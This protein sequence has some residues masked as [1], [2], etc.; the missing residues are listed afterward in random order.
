MD[1]GIWTPLPHT[2]RDEPTMAAAIASS[3]LRGPGKPDL[4]MQ[5]AIDVLQKAEAYGFSITLVA[6]RF[7]GPDLESWMLS[8]ALAAKTTRIKI[9]PAVHP[10]IICPQIA[11]KMGATLDRISGGRCAVNVVGGWH[12]EEFNIFGNGGWLDDD[13]GRYRRI[14][15][16]IQV[17][18][19]LWTEENFSFGGDFFK[20]VLGEVP[21]KPQQSP[22]PP[23]YA[24]GRTEAGKDTIAKHCD[25]WFIMAGADHKAHEQH[26]SAIAREVRDMRQRSSAHGRN[27]RCALNAHVVCATTNEEAMLRADELA[28]YG[29]GGRIPAIAVS[30]IGVGL[31]GA[32]EVIAERI[33][34]LEDI[35]I[36][37]LMLKFSPMLEQLD[38]FAE[39]VLP[40][41]GRERGL[42][43]SAAEA[44]VRARTSIV[45]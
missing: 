36:E 11:A 1:F 30:G 3:A 33:R 4:A 12:K 39:D 21:F 28:A 31:I 37:L 7:L 18:K 43:N 24:A 14:D 38:M 20:V 42:S 26:W 45:Q 10:G 27:V 25:T 23:I 19:G 17:L 2:I 13:Q 44:Q 9:M 41:L 6:E 40:L 5:F 16:F 34:R 15:E 29:K 8:S 22:C 35:G 32:P